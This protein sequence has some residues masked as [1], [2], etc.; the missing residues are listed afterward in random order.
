MNESFLIKKPWVLTNTLF[1]VLVYAVLFIFL[2]KVM[3]NLSIHLPQTRSSGLRAVLVRAAD[4]GSIGAWIREKELCTDPVFGDV[5]SGESVLEARKIALGAISSYELLLQT[6]LDLAERDFNQ[7]YR[8]VRSD[9]LYAK[10][11]CFSVYDKGLEV[12]ETSRVSLRESFDRVTQRPSFWYVPRSE[13]VGRIL[14][15]AQ[16][17]HDAQV[18]QGLKDASDPIRIVDIGSG[19][20][21]LS[22][23]IL[24]TAKKQGLQ[25][26]CEVVSPRLVIIQKQKELYAT[27][28]GLSFVCESWFD[29]LSRFWKEDAAI[30][31]DISNVM[32]LAKRAKESLRDLGVLQKVYCKDFLSRSISSKS[33]EL[34]ER[35]LSKDFGITFPDT[36][37]V[38]PGT[39]YQLFDSGVSFTDFMPL[40]EFLKKKYT[41]TFDR[42]L[43]QIEHG[44][45]STQVCNVDLLLQTRLLPGDELLTSMR[46]LGAGALCSI[47]DYRKSASHALAARRIRPTFFYGAEFQHYPPVCGWK[48][49]SVGVRLCDEDESGD[50]FAD[51]SEDGKRVVPPEGIDAEYPLPFFLLQTW[52]HLLGGVDFCAAVERVTPPRMFGWERILIDRRCLHNKI[53]RLQDLS[54]SSLRTIKRLIGRDR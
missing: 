51:F 11:I 26:T 25:V 33:V 38:R 50:I 6:Y 13:D 43:N 46:L 37:S 39:L 54:I 3:E 29:T 23:L 36:F 5:F 14:C 10:E 31:S 4:P 20:G 28:K 8:S 40:G 18:V 44:I 15:A 12:V 41:K 17:V 47:V 42:L 27:C 49:V 7:L 21:D 45:A 35:I 22:S 9:L 1:F 52:S 30:S 16:C 32:Q 19:Y 24:A 48:G 2:E 34:C 53:V